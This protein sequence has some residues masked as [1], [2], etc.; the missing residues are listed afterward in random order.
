MNVCA[1]PL[2]NICVFAR[3][4]KIYLAEQLHSD[5]IFTDMSVIRLTLMHQDIVLRDS[6]L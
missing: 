4:V 5:P 6:S 3:D 1:V 2:S